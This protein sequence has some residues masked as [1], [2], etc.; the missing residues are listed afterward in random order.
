MVTL[1]LRDIALLYTALDCYL[2]ELPPAD[3]DRAEKVLS[4]LRRY[5]PDDAGSAP[6]PGGAGSP[7][8][9]ARH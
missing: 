3:V 4:A 5:L 9:E 1:K 7:P 6:E 8:T 2:D